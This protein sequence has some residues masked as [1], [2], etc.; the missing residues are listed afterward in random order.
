M[1]DI[2][3]QPPGASPRSS[4]ELRKIANASRNGPDES[5]RRLIDITVAN[6]RRDCRCGEGWKEFRS[7]I[8][9]NSVRA[10]FGRACRRFTTP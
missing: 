5:A 3:N 6:D 8:R 9:K 4:G 2:T 1:L 7:R 10:A